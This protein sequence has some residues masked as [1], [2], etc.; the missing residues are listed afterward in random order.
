[1]SE[2][3]IWGICKARRLNAR[4]GCQVFIDIAV[5]DAGN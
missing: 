3:K 5:D 1:M 2:A 4:S